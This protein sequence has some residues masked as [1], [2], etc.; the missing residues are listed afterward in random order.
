MTVYLYLFFQERVR[1]S[2]VSFL[3]SA[4]AVGY[5]P[6]CGEKGKGSG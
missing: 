2:L 4:E 5:E 3:L 6:L 1:Q